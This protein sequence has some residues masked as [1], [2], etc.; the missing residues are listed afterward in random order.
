M[1][2]AGLVTSRGIE[3]MQG[4]RFHGAADDA[5]QASFP[6]VGNLPDDAE[7]VGCLTGVAVGSALIEHTCRIAAQRNEQTYGVQILRSLHADLPQ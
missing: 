5:A 7:S 1:T 3:Q 6:G 2:R 4:S